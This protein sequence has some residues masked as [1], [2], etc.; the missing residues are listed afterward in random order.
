[1]A[2]S[3]C[4]HSGALEGRI[5]APPALLLANARREAR[6]C[7]SSI[8]SP[9]FKRRS[10]DGPV[11]AP[12]SVGKVTQNFGSRAIRVAPGQA[13]LHYCEWI[14]FVHRNLWGTA[15]DAF[16]ELIPSLIRLG[17]NFS[18]RRHRSATFLWRGS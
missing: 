4:L 9:K 18:E 6:R 2:A 10:N 15:L 14:A 7:L 5:C 1:M 8:R 3:V 12:F 17:I 16:G 11:G 13:A